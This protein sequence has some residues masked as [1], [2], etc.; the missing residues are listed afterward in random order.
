MGAGKSKH[1][2]SSFKPSG[3][4]AS[5]PKKFIKPPHRPMT[6]KAKAVAVRQAVSIKK[7]AAPKAP[8]SAMN[9]VW[10]TQ[11]LTNPDTRKLL[12]A[13]AGEHSLHVIQEFTSQMSDEEIAKKTK[14]RS[15]DVRVVLNKLHSYGLASYTRS[16][17]KNSGWYS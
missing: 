8:R 11:L 17:D 16:R 2:K 9:R 15:S 4:R 14:I 5:N 3:A 1:K 10:K 6:A 12:I 13:A 7:A